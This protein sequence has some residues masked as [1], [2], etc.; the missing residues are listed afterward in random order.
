MR[1]A[2]F[3]EVNQI[4]EGNVLRKHRKPVFGR[5]ALALRPLDQQPFLRSQLGAPFVA[6][7]GANP[8][9]GKARA[10]WFMPVVNRLHYLI[11]NP[12]ARGFV[13]QSN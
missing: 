4:S 7:R 8:Q 9:A 5:L 3:G 1:Q 2:Q 6:M 11:L 12:V 10:Q 13:T